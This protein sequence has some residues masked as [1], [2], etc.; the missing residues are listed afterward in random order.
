M[1][2]SNPNR[3][4][5]KGSCHCGH[6]KY[7]AFLELPPRV[8]DANA[9]YDTTRI[10]KCNC[11]TCVKTGSFSVRLANAPTD[12]VLLAP[13]D[14]FKGLSSYQCGDKTSHWFFCTI[15]G[16]R[17]LT[18]AVDANNSEIVDIDL[19]EWLG[20]ESKGK[21][22]KVWRPKQEGWDEQKFETSYLSVNATSLDAGQ[23]GLDLREW[24][25][26]GWIVYLDCLDY[27]EENRLGRPCRGGQY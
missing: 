25:E 4:P 19:E 3:R 7:I 21:S 23:E 24:H 15:C 26:K 27:K 13:T 16:V 5:Y 18:F 9:P 11:T 17:C 1:S 22:T 10:R 12:F 20:K 8:I 14:P 2:V 6:T